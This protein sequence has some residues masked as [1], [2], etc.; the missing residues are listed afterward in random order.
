MTGVIEVSNLYKT[1]KIPR[2]EDIEVLKGITLKVSQGEFIAIMGPSGSG[3]ST[4]LNILSSIEDI[5]EGQVVI[6][7]EDRSQASE[8]DL[9]NT[10]RYATSI[11][12][13]DFNLLTYLTALENVMFPMM[14]VGMKEK[15]ARENALK[16]LQRVHLEHRINHTPDDLSGGEQQRVSIARALAN[17]PKVLLADEPTGNLDT[18]I[19]DSIIELF[20]EIIQETNCSVIMVTHDLQVAKKADRILILREGTLHREEDVLEEL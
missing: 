14:L 6:V 11:V 7:G 10:R 3:K 15:D 5:T 16:I 2:G 9:V 12:Y 1:F 8:T 4:L 19:G 17:N 18:K 20:Q 13:Q